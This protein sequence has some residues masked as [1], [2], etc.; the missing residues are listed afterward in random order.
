MRIVK[1]KERRAVIIVKICLHDFFYGKNI[2][3]THICKELLLTDH[4]KLYV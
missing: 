1:K 3:Y 2:A 4:S